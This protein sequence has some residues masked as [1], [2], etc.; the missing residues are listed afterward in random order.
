MASSPSPLTTSSA[1][2]SIAFSRTSSAVPA[3]SGKRNS[4]SRSNM[5]DTLLVSPRLPPYLLKLD[6]T[7]PAVRLR[8]LVRASTI[9]ATP[10]GP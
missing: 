7:S 8:L 5:N 10:P 1:P 3:L 4:P 9:S 6:R 2:A